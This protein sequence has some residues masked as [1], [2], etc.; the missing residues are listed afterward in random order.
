VITAPS[1]HEKLFPGDRLL[2]LGTDEQTRG[3]R[4]ELSGTS[5]PQELEF[6]DALLDTIDVADGP[7]VGATLAHLQI[8]VVTGVLLVGIDRDKCL[9]PN[10]SGT[11]K[12]LAGDQLLVLG[13]PRRIV[14]FRSWLAG[15]EDP[16]TDKESKG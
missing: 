11:E 2:L 13:T 5:S 3:A 1:P 16:P 7:H 15:I 12:I 9:I 4:E 10:P 8:P 14:H 6:Q